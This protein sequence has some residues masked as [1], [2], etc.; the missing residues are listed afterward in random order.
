M[1]LL[2]IDLYDDLV[3]ACDEMMGKKGGFQTEGSGWTFNSSHLLKIESWYSSSKYSLPEPHVPF[4]PTTP[5]TSPGPKLQW[6]CW[7]SY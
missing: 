2:S 5:V 4:Q 7:D 3:Q 1:L 6:G